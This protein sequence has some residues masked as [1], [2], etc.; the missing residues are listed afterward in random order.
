[1]SRKAQLKLIRAYLILAC[2]GGLLVQANSAS[3]NLAVKLTPRRKCLVRDTPWI[4]GKE[5]YQVVM[6]G[7]GCPRMNLSL[8]VN[9]R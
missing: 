4:T 6:L 9:T 1:M 2:L 3:A 8:I 7:V 5:P